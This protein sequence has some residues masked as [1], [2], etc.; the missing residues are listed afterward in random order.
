MSTDSENGAGFVEG[1]DDSDE[2]T[3]DDI[4]TITNAE[5]VEVQCAIVAVIVHDGEQY[6]MLQPVEQLADEEAEE[7]DSYVYHY[8]I[9]DDDAPVFSEIDD[10][11]AFETVC[12]IFSEM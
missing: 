9:N 1:F 4:V 7:I 5:G 12:E 10:D 2:F 8:S 3:D 11:A 6:V